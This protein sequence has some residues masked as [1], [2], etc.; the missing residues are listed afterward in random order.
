M[1]PPG[2][3][4]IDRFL[5]RLREL[6][7]S[8][9]AEMDRIDWTC[10]RDGCCCENSEFGPRPSELEILLIR[11]HL[12]AHPLPPGGATDGRDPCLFLSGSQCTIYQAR[13][14]GCRSFTCD[15]SS[16]QIYEDWKGKLEALAEEFRRATDQIRAPGRAVL[17]KHWFPAGR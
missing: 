15:F 3:D 2:N 11:R 10:R 8:V 4:D 14:F 6:Y 17:L 7:A 12:E 9:D 5:R 1:S 16:L 13:P